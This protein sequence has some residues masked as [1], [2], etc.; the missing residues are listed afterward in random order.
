MKQKHL[1]YIVFITGACVLIFQVAGIRF[2]APFF[3]GGLTTTSSIIGVMLGA[4][5]VGY[6][7]G[8]KLADKTPTFVRFFNLISLAGIVS[9][10][11][12][13]VHRRIMPLFAYNLP[14][15]WGVILFSITFFA[16][17]SFLLGTL[18]PFAVK[19]VTVG[20]K[21]VKV[22]QAAGDMFFYSTAGSITGSLLT[23]FYFIP[24]FGVSQIILTTSLVLA[25]MGLLGVYLSQ[26]KISEKLFLTLLVGVSVVFVF[27]REP[28]LPGL[29]YAKDGVY[30]RLA[31]VD[32][33]LSGKNIRLLYQDTN[34][35]SSV[36]LADPMRM[37]FDYSKTWE[38]PFFL[39]PNIKRVAIVGA[40]AYTLPRVISTRYP[41]VQIDVIDVEPG[42]MALS[43]KYFKLV[44]TEN[45]NEIIID[46]RRHF[47]KTPDGYY[48]Y[49]FLDAFS[50]KL[51]IPPHLM[52]KEFFALVKRKISDNGVVMANIIGNTL[53]NTFLNKQV[54]TIATSFPS[55]CLVATKGEGYGEDQNLIFHSFTPRKENCL[56]TEGGLTPFSDDYAPIE[57]SSRN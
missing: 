20:Q 28:Q 1:P 21:K 12:F 34:A 23:G 18:S 39:N 56:K 49:V 4:L 2:F 17:P 25:V 27:W 14:L 51:T 32:A 29:V 41:N 45:V 36:D 22:G 35:S 48:D 50:Q 44:D 24:N 13:V 5:A 6:R 52:T 33:T 9:G 42:L 37:V 3:G 8:G 31:V 38:E 30:Q 10:V 46:A 26:R 53:N 16:L 19:L 7:F 43:E 57:W 55:F 15:E 40:G 54:A 11:L 47:N